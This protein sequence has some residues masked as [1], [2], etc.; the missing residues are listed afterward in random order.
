MTRQERASNIVRDNVIYCVTM[1]V[2]DLLD[3]DILSY[4]D[5]CNLTVDKSEEI[6]EKEDAIEELECIISAFK[7]DLEYEDNINEIKG[8]ENEISINRKLLEKLR[9]ELEELQ[10]QDG[11]HQEA[12][13][14]WIV[15]DW[16]ADKLKERDEIILECEYFTAWGR[17]TSGQAIEMDSIILDIAEY[18]N[19]KYGE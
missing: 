2:E 10:E 6:S 16:I 11:T 19:N 7:S 4:D 17:G 13:E 5:M 14:W 3:K 9:E 15:D 18:L 8:I 1:L 12:Y